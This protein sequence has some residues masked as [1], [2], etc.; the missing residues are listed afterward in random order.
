MMKHLLSISLLFLGLNVFSQAFSVMYPFTG[1][2]STTVSNTGTIDPTPPPTATGVT[3]GSFTAVGTGTSTQANGV[4]SFSG[5]DIGAT[6]AVDTY[7]TMTGLLNP[8]KYYEVTI[9]PNSSTVSLSSITFN[10]SRS[11]TGPVS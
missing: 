5:W 8:V 7:S 1:V 2:T 6:N 9:T 4:F 11:S 3:F 10:M